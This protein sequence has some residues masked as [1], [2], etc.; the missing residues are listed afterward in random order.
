MAHLVKLRAGDTQYFRIVGTSNVLA[1][2]ATAFYKLTI[3]FAAKLNAY[4]DFDDEDGLYVVPLPLAIVDDAD[5]ALA[6]SV[7][8][9][10]AAL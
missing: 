1:G 7:V 8:N 6:I 5:L 4:S 2:A 10:T 3:D 9:V